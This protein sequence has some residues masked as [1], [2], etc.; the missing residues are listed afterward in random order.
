[1][2]FVNIGK[3]STRTQYSPS[4]PR[5]GSN[6]GIYTVSSAPNSPRVGNKCTPGSCKWIMFY[7]SILILLIHYQVINPLYLFIRTL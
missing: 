7:S 4:V 3:G 2:Y 5:K 1:M 6:L